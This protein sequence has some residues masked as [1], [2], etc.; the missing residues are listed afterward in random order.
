[1]Q[2]L[3]CLLALAVLAYG[4]RWY[5]RRSAAA[6]RA[7]EESFRQKSEVRRAI[8]GEVADLNR[9]EDE[10]D[11][12]GEGSDPG[13]RHKAESLR[14]QLERKCFSHRIPVSVVRRSRSAYRFRPKTPTQ[15]NDL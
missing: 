1:M 10:L 13:L 11:R 2:L 9:L 12:L 3:L 4:L 8:V 7:Q 6:Q 14:E 5:V 15:E